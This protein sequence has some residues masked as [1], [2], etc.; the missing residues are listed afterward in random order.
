MKRKAPK[1]AAL[2]VASSLVAVPV[3]QATAA[4]QHQSAKDDVQAAKEGKVAVI[5]IA[6]E[7]TDAILQLGSKD[8]ETLTLVA[9]AK[10]ENG[11]VITDK[12]IQ[13][14]SLDKKVAVV[15]KNGN[16]S[17]VRPG[18]AEIEAKMA[19]VR[20][21]FEV[22]VKFKDNSDRERAVREATAAIDALPSL[23]DLTLADAPAVAAARE[24]VN[25]ALALGAQ[26]SEIR[27]LD[28]LVDA[29]EKL[30]ELQPDPVLVLKEQTIVE[31]DEND[32]SIEQEQIVSVEDGAFADDLSKDH[33]LITNLPEGLNYDIRRIDGQSFSI[34]FTGKANHHADADDVA[35]ARV[36]VTKEKVAMATDDL[37]S[38]PFRFDFHDPD[39]LSIA[40]ARTMEGET[41]TIK[42]IV[43]AD[44]AAIG[45][46]KLSTFMQDQ[47][48][49]INIFNQNASLF[50][51]LVEGDKVEV[52]GKIT[53]Y[54]GLTEIVPAA[55]GVKVLSQNNPL[56]QPVAIDLAQLEEAS[57]A[58]PLE[59]T[60]VEVTGFIDSIPGSPAGGG[61]NVNL[62][63]SQF[64][65]VTLR[66]MQDSMDISSVKA[67]KWY[68]I[69][70]I[71]GQFDSG[72]QLLPRKESDLQLLTEQPD[73]P[74]Q[75]GSYPSVVSD[76]VDGD[77]VHLSEPVI[78]ITKVRY[79]N[80]DTPET[81]HTVNNEL[82]RN[83]K[84]HGEKAKAYLKTLLPAGEDVTVKVGVEATDDYGRLLAEVIRD[85]DQ[86]NTNMEMVQS[87]YAA[88]YFIWP[89]DE[90]VYEPYSR[91][92]KE[93]VLDG[94]GIWNPYD[95]LLELPFE[96]RG[97]EQGK[98]LT[99][100]VGNYYTHE[101]VAPE[102]FKAIPVEARVFFA[103]PEE[104]EENG[105]D[106]MPAQ[107]VAD[108]LTVA[109]DKAALK[110]DYDGTSPVI[111]LP[112]AG[113]G[114]STIEW[115]LRNPV[116]SDLIQLSTGTVNREGLMHDTTVT[117]VATIKK[118]EAVDVQ[119]FPVLIKA[120]SG[121]T[122]DPVVTDLLISEY[123]EGTSNNKAIEIYNGTDQEIDLAAGGYAL[124]LYANGNTSP[125]N[126][127]T[128]TG[129][130]AAGSTYVIANAS[131]N[132]AILEKAQATSTVTYFNGD[133]A[134]VLYKNFD[135][136][137]KTGT[138]IDVIG[139]V[140]VDPGTAW[141]T[142]VRTVDQTLVRKSS[143]HKGNTSVNGPFDP[144]DE[145][146]SKG[147]DVID[148]LGKHKIE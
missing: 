74:T 69:T 60:L 100:Y 136:T 58:E 96:F 93:A 127:F 27:N 112:T 34:A 20:A 18:T 140:G 95:P 17:A 126:T 64:H 120:E 77:T 7:A 141:G 98:G 55:D 29:E 14:K 144:A 82:D 49:G 38:E 123:V 113:E 92:V 75:A 25:A 37:K 31:A 134:L 101:Y 105:Y 129:K 10:D 107:E 15:D 80:I 122:P 54:R 3:L 26:E 84:V 21:V 33:V 117:L 79:V 109:A 116:Q 41:V 103:S 114:G 4:P 137:T 5:E 70:A 12:K 76:V 78:G 147:I 106:P 23:D 138:V 30:R 9:T 36:I 35:D 57:A 131:A 110:L 146:E 104:A 86:L 44:N 8:D 68:K 32:G 2:L 66:I 85:R 143:V 46:G 52:T 89:F 13:W 72:Y 43:T 119:G 132:A 81:Y 91:A 99:R 130:L 16:V 121:T 83:Q 124:V 125:T 48:G 142:G 28:E 56:P 111:A 128:F 97:R 67:K 133:D 88:T 45:G 53:V 102:E 50:P 87:G 145:W 59:G 11:N 51:E 22:T 108:G 94:K 19:N 63:D 1:I 118:G 24:K 39:Q 6:N 73:P 61:Y 47:S 65:G 139:A 42:G 115:S 135:P 62:I 90:E 148:D 40:K 71:V